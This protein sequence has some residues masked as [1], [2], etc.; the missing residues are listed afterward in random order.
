MNIDDAINVYTDGSSFSKPRRTGGIGIRLVIV[1]SL[2]CEEFEDILLTGYPGATSN[3]MELHACIDGIKEA[4][5]HSSFGSFKRIAI[6]SDSKYVVDN[7]IRARCGWSRNRWRNYQG[8][9]VDNAPLWKKL[10]KTV[11]KCPKRVEFHWVKGHAKD[12]HNKAADKLARQSAKNAFNPSLSIV[13][14][15]RKLSTKSV[16]PGCV[17]MQ[18]QRISIRIITDEYLRLQ[19]CYKFKYEVISKNSPHYRKVDLAYSKLMLNAGHCYS[20]RFND[21]PKNPTII[22]VFKELPKLKK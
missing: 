1:N 10:L 12:Q 6:H 21:N 19:K 14:V 11:G 4:M 9:P 20:V 18:N 16:V 3:Q 8:K 5:R 17:P 7:Y 13:K 22:K 15:R 2:G